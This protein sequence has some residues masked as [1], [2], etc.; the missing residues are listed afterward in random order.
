[1]DKSIEATT[2]ELTSVEKL[3]QLQD[4]LAQEQAAAQSRFDQFVIGLQQEGFGLRVVETRVN[5]GTAEIRIDVV[6]K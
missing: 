6:R 4:L 5:G 1:M 2:P 3:K